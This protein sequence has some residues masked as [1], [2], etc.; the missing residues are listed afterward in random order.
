MSGVIVEIVTEYEMEEPW[1][2]PRERATSHT[3]A[4]HLLRNAHDPLHR[5]EE[6][7]IEIDWDRVHAVVQQ[8]LARLRTAVCDQSGLTI[9]QPGR[10]RTRGFP[11]FSYLAFSRPE[12]EAEAIVVGLTFTPRNHGFEIVGDVAGEESGQIY[13]DDVASCPAPAAFESVLEA[14][15]Q[16]AAHLADRPD[17]VLSAM[18]HP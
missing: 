13:Y 1:G 6:P 10:T 5:L 17:V 9:V 7:S 8:E 3:P 2:A 14:V 16:I 15:R 18:D 12:S 4:P 11:L